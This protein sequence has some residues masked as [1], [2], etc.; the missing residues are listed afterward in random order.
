MQIQILDNG[1]TVFVDEDIRMLTDEQVRQVG[2]LIVSNM[3]VV[4]KNQSLSTEDE[5][6]F[7]K[8]IGK[9]QYYPVE[10]ERIKHIRLTDHILRVTG[11]RN[12]DGEQGLHGHKVALDWHANQPSNKERD[13]LIWLHGVKGTKGSRTSWINN[14]ASYEALSDEMK[15]KI[16]DIKVYCG[17]EYGKYSQTTIFND[18]VNRDNLI[19]LV[20]TNK[21]G[22][23]GIFFPFLQIFGFDGYEQEEFDSIMQE[24]I[25]HVLKDEFAYHHDWED[26]DIVISEQWLSIHKRWDFDGMDN[27]ILHRIAFDY[28]N[29]YG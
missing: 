14:I 9:C 6:R 23:T 28:S 2:K 16:A 1:W 11:Q 7:C 20:H 26:G 19:D 10:A 15:S 18:H 13:P 22:K 17:H 4:F 24:L 29:L 3:V 8:I 27:R 12:K 5:E 21:E 25:D